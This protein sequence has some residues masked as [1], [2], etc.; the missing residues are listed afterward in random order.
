[1]N[2][3]RRGI[4]I[5]INLD[6]VKGGFSE[7]T[8]RSIFARRPG[9]TERP[10]V[11][12]LWVKMRCVP[13]RLMLLT[14][15]LLTQQIP[16][17]GLSLSCEDG[18]GG[19][20]TATWLSPVPQGN[21]FRDLFF[22][23][24]QYGWAVGECGSILH[25]RDGG[26]QWQIQYSG[27]DEQFNKIVFSSRE[28]GWIL[29][30]TLLLQTTDGGVKWHAVSV[31]SLRASKYV[32]AEDIISLSS[33]F[34]SVLTT[35]G[36]WTT[37]NQGTTWTLVREFS[38]ATAMSYT[39]SLHAWVCYDRGHISKTSDG[40]MEWEE[41]WLIKPGPAIRSI[42]FLDSSRGWAYDDGLVY[43]STNGGRTWAR[44][45]G[46]TSRYLNPCSEEFMLPSQIFDFYL[47]DSLRMWLAGRDG[48]WRSIDG[49]ESW[50][51]VLKTE[52]PMMTIGFAANGHGWAAGYPNRLMKSSDGGISWLDTTTTFTDASLNAV[53]FPAMGT[54]IAVSVAGIFRS[55]DG[56]LQWGSVDAP[57]DTLLRA[58]TF[59]G[60]SRGWIVGDRGR[61][62]S[63]DDTGRTWKSQFLHDSTDLL[64]AFFLNE[65]LGWICG[66]SGSIFRST[67]GGRTWN[68]MNN[69]SNQAL[70][71]VCFT[72]EQHGYCYGRRKN[73]YRTSDGGMT[74]QSIDFG[75]YTDLGNCHA[76]VS[77]GVDILTMT[78]DAVKR[79]AQVAR[80]TDHGRT[81]RRTSIEDAKFPIAIG[82]SD[83]KH[84]WIYSIGGG[85]RV[86]ED[87]G[88]SWS[89]LPL[90]FQFWG[91]AMEV[92][93]K[94][95]IILVGSYGEVVRVDWEWAVE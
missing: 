81:W 91:S 38:D 73:V 22:Y 61:I 51:H 83:E 66:A 15:L 84:G 58:M 6:S 28:C 5:D 16:A 37:N 63:T 3:L 10:S 85:L 29:G 87:G 43:R 12:F 42:V 86:T 17:Q 88:A 74:W 71:R 79:T 54:G 9:I 50:Q 13:Y 59:A 19:R 52:F 57:D 11:I 44:G 26:R 72:D 68:R 1:M 18:R 69:V 24:D 25:T 75:E 21:T 67:D 35:E 14:C 80:S 40:G 55:T 46:A 45:N 82:Y 94:D 60:P 20:V 95:A 65:R 53:C 90:P 62:L 36:L 2:R 78:S 33:D 32:Y 47:V 48:L 49:A 30:R 4:V 64:S 41:Y 56:G 93:S 39:D 92:L 27:M 76:G 89:T 34:S 7:P 31:P 70:G 77:G 23:D 8:N